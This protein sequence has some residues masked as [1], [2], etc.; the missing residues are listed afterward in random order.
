MRPSPECAVP[1]SPSCSRLQFARSGHLT[2]SRP[3]P[4]MPCTDYSAAMTMSN[5]HGEKVRGARLGAQAAD[6]ECANHPFLCGGSRGS[7][8]HSSC[9][10]CPGDPIVPVLLLRPRRRFVAAGPPGSGIQCGSPPGSPSPSRD[11]ASCESMCRTSQA[12]GGRPD[13]QPA[14]ETSPG[15]SPS[16][17]EAPAGGTEPPSPSGSGPPPPGRV[18]APRAPSEQKLAACLCARHFGVLTSSYLA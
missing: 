13:G 14:R 7:R 18:P 11:L 3:D 1:V 4:T 6:D 9:L 16:P 2:C 15:A 17:S 5:E 10:Q 12:R 8:A